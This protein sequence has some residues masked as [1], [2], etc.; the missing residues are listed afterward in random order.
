MKKGF[1]VL[2]VIMMAFVLVPGA[3]AADLKKIPLKWSDHASSVA[4]GNV[5]MKTVWV[6][7]INAQI[8]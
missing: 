7:R 3:M 1:C 8:T 6:P 5:L 4:G 2:F